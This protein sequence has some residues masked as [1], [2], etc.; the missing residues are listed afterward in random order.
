MAVVKTTRQE[1]LASKGLE[2]IEAANAPLF[3]EQEAGVTVPILSF[4]R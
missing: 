4:C 3:F 2:A 1:K